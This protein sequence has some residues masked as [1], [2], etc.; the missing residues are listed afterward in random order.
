M[1]T[2]LNG[3]LNAFAQNLT[4]IQAAPSHQTVYATELLPAD[5]NLG[6]QLLAPIQLEGVENFLNGIQK[7]GIQ[8]VTIDVSY[9]ILSPTYANYSQYLNFYEKVVQQVRD[10]GMKIDIE[11]ETPLLV[12]YPGIDTGSLSYSNL[13]YSTY[14]A[15]DRQMLQNVINYLHPDF[16]NI[17]TETDTLQFILPY[18]QISTPQGWGTYIASLLDGLNKNTTKIA[19]GIGAWDPISYLYAT[20]N[21]SAVDIINLHVYPIYGDDLSILTQ[22]GQLSKQYNKAIDIDEMW[23]HKSVMNKGQTQP[24]SFFTVDANISQ[25]NI[26]SFWAPL[27]EKFL[28]VMNEYASVFDVAFMSPFQATEFFAFVNYNQTT[29]NLGYNAA[30]QAE[31]QAASKNIQSGNISPLG[32]F[33]ENMVSG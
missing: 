27:D 32:C 4:T 17:G 3:I 20:L 13:N 19:V 26:Y 16:L 15:Q 7:M 12:G 18:Q 14:V 8:G 30:M 31:N 6:T 1:Y 29:A 22:I 10:R 33:Y 9:P 2:T 25:R 21:D 23:V 5:S 11:S 28:Q 24:G